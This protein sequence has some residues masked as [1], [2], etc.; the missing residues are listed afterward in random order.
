ML[1]F[2]KS[3]IAIPLI[4][5]L[6]IIILLKP[7]N[8]F[9]HETA[10]PISV[11]YD[12][13]SDETKDLR[14]SLSASIDSLATLRP[15]VQRAVAQ[16][17]YY[18]QLKESYQKQEAEII[19]KPIVD[20]SA[21]I[22]LR[23]KLNAANKEIDRLN[24]EIAVL[25]YKKA[26]PTKEVPSYIQPEI[27][28]PDENSIVIQLDGRSRKGD[29]PISSNFTI[30]LIPG[31]G[32]KYQKY[33][34]ACPEELTGNITAKYYNGL[35]FFNSVQ[36]GKYLIKIC[37]YYGNFKVINKPSGKYNVKMLIAPPI[38]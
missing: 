26:E 9:D 17:K 34:A 1:V 14:D 23:S 20:S 38:Q 30:Y 31:N 22:A 8:K 16:L 10:S 32:K 13:L 3:L 6:T 28:V 18:E 36:P 7:C 19:Y 15:I 29:I 37:T 2:K 24:G 12:S 33:E 4:V 27:E 25:S 11:P 21:I 35:Y 5:I